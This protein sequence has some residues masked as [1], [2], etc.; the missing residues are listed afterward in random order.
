MNNRDVL[1]SRLFKEKWV[2]TAEMSV[3]VEAKRI[4]LLTGT[5]RRIVEPV[6]IE[7]PINIYLNDRYLITLLATPQ[8]QKEL[9]LGWLFDEGVLQSPDE[10]RSVAV[11]V[12]N[13]QVE[14]K[15]P[16]QEE[17]LRVVG[18]TRILTTACGLSARKFLK[19]IG[20]AVKASVSSD[21]K[22]KAGDIIRMLQKLEDSSELFKQT[23]GTHASMLFDDGELV[24]FAEDISR[25]NAIDKAIGIAFLQKA[26]F[27]RCVLVSSG[28]QPADTV[29]KAAKMGIPILVSKASPIRSGIIAAEKT[30]VTLV[31]F[32]REHRMNV[33]THPDRILA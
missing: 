2:G 29:L 22:A 9:A 17:R 12:N 27:S 30:G 33:Y 1:H 15:E 31:C 11:N 5:R 21:Y 19:V 13:I 7:A 14:T 6:A 25:H 3:N 18:V 10:I 23:G 8:L 26:D 24:A 16:L 32:V 28:R 20:E 4:D